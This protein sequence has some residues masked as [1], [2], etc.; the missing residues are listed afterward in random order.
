M[1]P[2]APQARAFFYGKKLDI[3]GKKLDIYGKKLDI[4]DK[5][6][7]INKVQKPLLGKN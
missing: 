3:Y 2:I 5:E 6:L 1:Q 4:Y 7:D